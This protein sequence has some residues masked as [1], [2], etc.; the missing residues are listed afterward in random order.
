MDK[1]AWITKWESLWVYT[2]TQCV[3]ILQDKP[4]STQTLEWPNSVRTHL[5]TWAEHRAL[6]NIYE[7]L[8]LHDWSN[9]LYIYNRVCKCLILETTS[10]YAYVHVPTCIYSTYVPLQWVMFCRTYPDGQKHCSVWLTIA[11]SCEHPW[12]VGQTSRADET[13]GIDKKQNWT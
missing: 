5:F 9:L 11:Q 4:W 3:I 7:K 6:I 12:L 13:M 8:A 10:S 2:F 1:V